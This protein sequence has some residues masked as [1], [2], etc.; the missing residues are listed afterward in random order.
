M[1]K[2]HL[3]AVLARINAAPEGSEIPL[4]VEEAG[5]LHAFLAVRHR[6]GEVSAREQALLNRIDAIMASWR[7]PSEPGEGSQRRHQMMLRTA[8]DKAQSNHWDTLHA[9]ELELLRSTHHML[10]SVDATNKG[11]ERLY[12]L[13]TDLLKRY[14]AYC[15]RRSGA[16]ANGSGT[17]A[18]GFGAQ[19]AIVI[20][21]V[22]PHP[23][24]SATVLQATNYFQR[25]TPAA[26]VFVGG[27]PVSLTVRTF[28]VDGPVKIEGDIP[29][30]VLLRVKGGSITVEG[31][32]SGHVVADGNVIV[33]GNVQGGWVI[34]TRGSIVVDRALLGS[35]VVAEAGV[36]WCTGVEAAACVFGWDGVAV[37]ETALSSFL[38][39]GRVWVGEKLAGTTVEACGPVV[40]QSIEGANLGPSTVCLQREVSSEVY[41]RQVSEGA[42]AMRR[43]VA[44][45]E[46]TI[47]QGE[48]LMR[49]VRLLSQNCYRTAIFYLVGG[50]R[51][52]GAAP[53]F[54]ELQALALH[55]EEI[56][57]SAEGVSQFYERIFSGA[58]S[59]DAAEVAFFTSEVLKSLSYITQQVEGASQEVQSRLHAVLLNHVQAFTRS[60]RFLQRNVDN[61]KG[62]TYFRDIYHGN[63]RDWRDQY[64]KTRQKVEALEET[65]EVHPELLERV[66]VERDSLDKLLNEVMLRASASD[67]SDEA[68]RAHSP[69]IRVLQSTVERNRKS[70][71]HVQN[72]VNQARREM[73]R[74]RR[75]LAE[76]TAV[77]F[78]DAK[79][80]SV[81]AEAVSIEPGTILTTAPNLRQGVD[82]TMREVIVIQQPV[83]GSTRFVLD[84]TVLRR[85]DGRMQGTAT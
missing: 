5:L 52:A 42:L 61:P 6:S 37:R 84:R 35:R 70:I 85:V 46:R 32:V 73:D 23:E 48:R 65:F 16:E 57:N 26:V 21:A 28:E 9:E 22:P 78:A 11:N 82:G 50:V 17:G 77:Q 4:T 67:A 71:Q 68:V 60:L 83:H 58:E 41:G 81:Y 15:A 45:H 62:A 14:D 12:S 30:D 3:Q 8:I 47:Q 7:P 55:L 31:F 53:E 33:R 74:L 39:G 24:T 20:A 19:C 34:A 18:V 10:G 43:S 72:E 69:L 27:C 54:Q 38:A 29:S 51:A 64:A 1:D 36:V 40:M 63:M 79:P 49:Y 44:Q 75:Q 59:A 80:D 56:L 25:V 13:L 66:R 2:T 76:E